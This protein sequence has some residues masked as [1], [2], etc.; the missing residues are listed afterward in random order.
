MNRIRQTLWVGAITC[1]ILVVGCG[2]TYM[3][4]K[5]EEAR[6]RWA[7]SRA[8]MATRLAQ[9]CFERGEIGHAHD[10]LEAAIQSGAPYAPM[11]ILAARL[12]VENGELDAARQYAERA[13]SLDPKSGEACYVLGT[14]EQMLGDADGALSAYSEAVRRDPGR[15]AYVLAEAELLTSQGQAELALHYLEEAI[16]RMPGRSEVHAAMGDLLC[17]LDR[18]EEAVGAYQIALR[19][20]PTQEGLKEHLVTALFFSGRYAEAELLLSEL[21]ESGAEAPAG[22]ALKMRG[23]C[24]LALGRIAEARPLYERFLEDGRTSADVLVALAKCDI[25]EDRPGPA[26]DRL[27][28]ALKQA[29]QH[30]EANALMGYL[31]VAEGRPGEAVSHLRLALAAPDCAERE[32]VEWLLARATEKTTGPTGEAGEVSRPADSESGGSA[33]PPAAGAGAESLGG[34]VR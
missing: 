14:V 13:R 28:S 32:I 17:L 5:R 2:Q 21:T 12:A 1:A 3:G 7:L 22:W 16:G 11:Y 10:H 33:G 4:R 18:H 24:L 25:L 8:E 31:L 6:E 19:L 30:A 27:E 15:S 23:D 34:I 26:R 9:G 20:D 29:P